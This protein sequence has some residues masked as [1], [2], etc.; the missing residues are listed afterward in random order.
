MKR[1]V[2]R[3][4][5]SEQEQ[6]SARLLEA[7][8]TAFCRFGLSG[9]S[10]DRIAS[11]AGI[12]KHTIY[13]RF[14]SKEELL[15]A[16]VEWEL[17]RIASFSCLP[18]AQHLSPLDVLKTHAEA[19]FT[20]SLEPENIAWRAFLRAES[21]FSPV[22]LRKLASWDRTAAAP[23]V[24]AIKEAQ[25]CATLEP[26]DPEAVCDILFSLIDGGERWWRWGGDGIPPMRDRNTFFARRWTL[27]LHVF[28]AQ[29]R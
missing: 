22:L 24:A 20:Y 7:A 4:S 16:V 9:T 28:G 15:D 2:G 11:D 8:R 12:T 17:K 19:R 29:S 10:M 3:P 18:V 25:A 1:T 5:R 27:F 26:G 6:I 21:T 13:R 23:F 14:A